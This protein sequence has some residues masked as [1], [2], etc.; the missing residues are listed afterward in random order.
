MTVEIELTQGQVTIVDDIDADLAEVKWATQPR[1]NGLDFYALRGTYSSTT[2]TKRTTVH[3]HR[4]VLERKLGRALRKGEIVDHI[5]GNGLN[6][7]RSNLRLATQAENR[8][9]SRKNVNNT[10]G[11]KG[12]Y[13][14]KSSQKWM[15][16]ITFNRRMIYLGYF[17]C[18][19]EAHAVYCKAAAKYHGEFANFGQV[20][21]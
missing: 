18:P 8:R 7:R 9:N 13:W 6:N 1:N 4:A 17:D 10:S 2:K 16:Y 14:H 5:D 20:Q 19:K 15:A 11:F 3:L 12:V 21:S